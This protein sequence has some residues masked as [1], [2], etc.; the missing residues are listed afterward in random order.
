MARIPDEELERL[1]AEESVEHLVAAAGVDLKAA[2]KDYSAAARSTRT[3]R[4][5]WS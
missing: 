5:R 2:G 3:G 4:L 1:K